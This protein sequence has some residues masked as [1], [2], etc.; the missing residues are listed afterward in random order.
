MFSPDRF[1]QN[2]IDFAVIDYSHAS[3][4][5]NGGPRKGAGCKEGPRKGS[6]SSR[7]DFSGPPVEDG[8]GFMPS[9]LVDSSKKNFLNDL[10]SRVFH[11]VII[12][13]MSCGYLW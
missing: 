13:A 1:G 10:T 2:A 12:L 4:G 9:D 11:L 8:R 3:S 7:K 6:S 5:R